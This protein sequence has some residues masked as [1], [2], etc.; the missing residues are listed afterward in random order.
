MIQ[1]VTPILLMACGLSMA[2][3]AVDF[4]RAKGA[5]PKES[6]VSVE[7]AQLPTFR[8]GKKGAQTVI[9]IHGGPGLPGYMRSL[10][11][12]LATEFSLVEYYQ[13]DALVA[14][15]R[16]KHS[17]DIYVKDL[18]A[19]VESTAKPAVL[20][21]HSM[22]AVIALEFAKRYPKLTKRLVLVGPA[23]LDKASDDTFQ[24]TVTA[25]NRK[26][27]SKWDE[28][29]DARYK[30]L[31]RAKTPKEKSTALHRYLELIWPAYSPSRKT[32]AELVFAEVDVEAGN[33]IENEYKGKLS[34]GSFIMGL[35]MIESP[36]VHIHGASDP[37]PSAA[38]R[39]Y[40]SKTKSYQFIPVAEA[41]HFPW[42]DDLPK[43]HFLAPL[44]SSLN[45]K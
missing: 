32:P 23:A 17:I 33:A 27:D 6:F 11:L 42:L 9:L 30:E 16:G 7:G 3:H 28:K 45:M 19:I 2:E 15:A 21:A 13:R 35:E 38:T 18:K 26:L 41:G 1:L 34:N 39:K 14:K 36:I 37:I 29:V 40:L 4:A 10:G 12:R 31:L 20:L 22:G 8:Y 44:I 5:V 25:R 24:K 43:S